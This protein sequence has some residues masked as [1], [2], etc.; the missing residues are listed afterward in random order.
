MIL[1]FKM[2]T[3]SIDVNLFH[4]ECIATIKVAQKCLKIIF[5]YNMFILFYLSRFLSFFPGRESF[6]MKRIRSE[7]YSKRFQWD[8]T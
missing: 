6:Y 2:Y 4:M 8:T 5:Q 1:R 3:A 7:I